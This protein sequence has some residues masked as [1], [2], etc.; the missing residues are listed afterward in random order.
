MKSKKGNQLKD[1]LPDGKVS[2]PAQFIINK[3]GSSVIVKIEADL[4]SLLI[5]SKE[6]PI[7]K[8]EKKK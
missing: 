8:V 7:L 1:L 5:S 2:L 6:N 4:K 3:M